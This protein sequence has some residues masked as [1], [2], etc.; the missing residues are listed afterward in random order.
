MSFDN[1]DKRFVGVDDESTISV[2]LRFMLFIPMV[3]AESIK[4]KDMYY[5]ITMNNLSSLKD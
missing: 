5:F 1:K 4:Y 3:T 2:D